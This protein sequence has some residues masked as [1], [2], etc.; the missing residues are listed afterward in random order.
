MLRDTGGLFL[1]S[2]PLPLP[3]QSEQL[4]EFRGLN[5]PEIPF[6]WNVET[7][8]ASMCRNFT[9]RMACTPRPLTD[10]VAVDNPADEI[11]GE[12]V[13]MRAL[14]WPRFRVACGGNQVSLPVG[15]AKTL[16]EFEAACSAA[17][18]FPLVSAQCGNKP[19]GSCSHYDVYVCKRPVYMAL[20]LD[21]QGHNCSCQLVGE[22]GTPRPKPLAESALRQAL[23]SRAQQPNS[24]RNVNSV[25]KNGAAT[26]RRRR[27]LDK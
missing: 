27:V 12:P 1:C 21:R 16:E 18:I 25:N 20:R 14:P 13:I 22:R 10:A 23:S 7:A 6:Y 5:M 24:T 2:V 11:H 17:G 3:H 15:V 4:V 26:V 19:F 9:P 8:C